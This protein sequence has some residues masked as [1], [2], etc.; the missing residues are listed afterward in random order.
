[1]VSLWKL[2]IADKAKMKLMIKRGEF[3][4]KLKQISM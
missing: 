3:S 4:T 2:N 1:M